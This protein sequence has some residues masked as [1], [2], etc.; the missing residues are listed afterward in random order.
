MTLSALGSV[1]LSASAFGQGF[2]GPRPAIPGPD[3]I[4]P[5]GNYLPREVR[6]REALQPRPQGPGVGY[7]VTYFGWP[8]VP[9]YG[10]TAYGPGLSGLGPLALVSNYPHAGYGYTAPGTEAVLRT[11]IAENDRLAREAAERARARPATLTLELPAPAGL[12]VNDIFYEAVESRSVIT[13]DALPPGTP[14]TLDVYAEWTV[15]GKRYE[16][17]RVVTVAAGEK[18]RLV[19]GRGFPVK[20]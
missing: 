10:G 5:R 12:W 9:Y 13:S 19:V 7:G 2:A 20:K 3:R 14:V 1:L 6:F 17:S 15:D 8:I 4:A 11:E 18:S 16:W